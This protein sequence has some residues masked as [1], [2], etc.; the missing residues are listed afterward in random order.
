M[1]CVAGEIALPRHETFKP[2]AELLQC[3]HQCQHFRVG[4]FG[5]SIEM[6]SL[7]ITLD[8]ID[9]A[10]GIGELKHGRDCTPA[11]HV[12]G[13]GQDVDQQQN[14]GQRRDSE[15]EREAGNLHF[16]EYQDQALA[17]VLAD[18][19][20][21][22]GTLGRSLLAEARLQLLQ[23]LRR[24]IGSRPANEVATQVV[25]IWQR[26]SR[27]G[28][29]SIPEMLGLTIQ[30]LAHQNLLDNESCRVYT[31]HRSDR[32]R[33]DLEHE[34]AHQ[35]GLDAALENLVENFHRRGLCAR[36]GL[37]EQEVSDHPLAATGK[38]KQ[39]FASHEKHSPPLQLPIGR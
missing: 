34:H 13:P 32:D 23:P 25:G 39:F 15:K 38:G 7:E 24:R 1:R 10:H 28:A 19:N 37:L 14:A 27:V 26:C 16:V 22:V 6:Q 21:R 17:V 5:E 33:Q 4:G 29:I 2:V 36:T 30:R 8:E 20:H 35:F 31:K 12:A 18:M 9:A 3:V 11:H